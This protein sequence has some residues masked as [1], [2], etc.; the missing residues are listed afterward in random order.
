MSER[1]PLGFLANMLRGFTMGAADMVPGVS[2]GTVA[3]VLGIYRTLV[4]SIRSGSTAMGN[5][6]KLDFGGMLAHLREVSW[7]FLISLVLGI[8]LA[9]GLLAGVIEHA[10]ATYPIL[11]SGLFLG[12]VAGSVVIAWQLVEQWQA[13]Y[14]V[15]FVVSAVLV[16]F[17]LGLGGGEE[18]AGLSTPPMWAYF[19][20]G[21]VAICAMILPGI[22]GSFILVMLGMYP[23]ILAAVADRNFAVMG[24]VL[25]GCIVGLALF[26]QVLHWAL[27]HYHDLV[28]AALI[29]L[30]VGSLRVLWPWPG[31]VESTQLALPDQQIVGTIALAVAGFGVVVAF[32]VVAKRIE[33]RTN[34]EESA[35][36]KA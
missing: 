29:G 25:V 30:M 12:L 4:G 26:S 17:G 36:L 8:V 21:A 7:A 5:A 3:L 14:L 9:L 2:G 10:L 1:T 27:E 16:F 32:H 34:A 23:P 20:A 22:S 31:G 6:L 15:V 19:A 24:L 28:M 11:M 13:R 35:D 18:T 33:H